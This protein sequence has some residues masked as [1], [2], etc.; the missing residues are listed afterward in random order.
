MR[1]SMSVKA[2]RLPTAILSKIS[3]T[4]AALGE[5]PPDSHFHIDKE[6]TPSSCPICSWVKPSRARWAFRRSA[7][8]V[9]FRPGFPRGVSGLGLAVDEGL[10]KEPAKEGVARN[11]SSFFKLD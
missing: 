5:A 10:A 11:L 4:R 2:S 7:V 1:C 6:D 9:T 8:N 3:G